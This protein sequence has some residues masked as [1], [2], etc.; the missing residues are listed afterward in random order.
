[1][2][3]DEIH[4]GDIGTVFSVTVKDGTTVVDISN[5]S[6][7]QILLQDPDG[8]TQTKTAEYET[9]GTDG[10]IKYTTV[11]GDLTLAGTW[12][13]QAKVVITA[14]TWNTDV[15]EFKVYANL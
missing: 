6:T 2:A 13:I 5:A 3:A 1:M 11:S 14:G 12:K 8:T 7:K 10:V 15:Q 9:D 4:V